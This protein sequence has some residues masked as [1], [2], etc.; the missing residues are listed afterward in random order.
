MIS[1]SNKLSNNSNKVDDVCSNCIG[2]RNGTSSPRPET[3]CVPMRSCAMGYESSPGSYASSGSEHRRRPLN[4]S[5]AVRDQNTRIGDSIESNAITYHSAF[6]NLTRNISRQSYIR[7]P[8][9][10]AT[11][12]SKNITFIIRESYGT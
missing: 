5:R 7:Q 8:K 12:K 1:S 10:T 2:L 9:N 4:Q 11:S 6:A 3:D